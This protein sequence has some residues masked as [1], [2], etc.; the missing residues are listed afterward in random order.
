MQH[1]NTF[2]AFLIGSLAMLACTTPAEVASR[3]EA[4]GGSTNIG[5]GTSD[6]QGGS[7][8]GGGTSDSQGGTPSGGATNGVAG[9]GVAD[10]LRSDLAPITA[11]DVTDA[12]YAAFISDSNAFGLELQQQLVTTQ[13]LAAE[14]GVF[15]PVSAQLALAMTYGAA[16]GDTAAGMKTAL[17]DNLGGVKYHSASNRLMREL[18][19][20]N[21]TNTDSQ[22]Y[23]RRIELAPANSLWVD[24]TVAVK[25]PYLD[26]L[27]QQYDSGMRRVDF[28]G[29]PN[30]SR[31]AI[32]AWVEDKTHDK[33]KD[34]LLP[35]DISTDTRFVIVNALYFYGTWAT[36]F[37]KT[38]TQPATFHALAGT[39][40]EASMMHKSSTWKHKSTD[41]VE[42]LQLPYVM[43]KLWMTVVLPSLGQFE[44]TRAQVSAAWL[45]RMTD[46]L[47]SRYI[48][49]ALPKFKIETPQLMLTE[50]LK[51]MGMASAFAQTADFSGMTD[52]KPLFISTVIQKAFIGV[53]E[54]GTEAAAAT[55][56]IGDTVSLPPTPI[57]VTVDRP[58]LYFIQDQTG[59]VL[60]SGQ[61][62]DPT[63]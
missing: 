29:Q 17:H 19:S 35:P 11:P 40:V 44:A 34:L 45:A 9:S 7:A 5:G 49:L 43:D 38:G 37:P 59:L 3:S 39:D 18:S 22:G 33:I 56:V 60:F 54:D 6:A 53:D 58:F 57:P 63:K 12:E 23:V 50:G 31:L 14:N 52:L 30:P 46:G 42:V 16:V 21:Y 51:A 1:L 32:N 61:V 41:S 47:T 48:Q 28:I 36:I 20:R 15:S 4:E 26:L 10:D 13:R 2:T 8:S 27:G 24:K 62:V 55:A 25:T